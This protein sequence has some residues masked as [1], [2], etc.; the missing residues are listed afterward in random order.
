[1]RK[2]KKV[3]LFIV[4]CICVVNLI[5]WTGCTTAQSQMVRNIFDEMYYAAI[6][7]YIYS[8]SLNSF[9]TKA[10]FSNVSSYQNMQ[11]EAQYTYEN[12]KLIM[13]CNVYKHSYLNKNESI[14]IRANYQKKNIDFVLS[15]DCGIDG[16]NVY[17]GE[18]ILNI[19][20]RYNV[21]NQCL[22]LS[23]WIVSDMLGITCSS[24]VVKEFMK[25]HNI[26]DEDLEYYKNYM[27][28]EK[29][30]PDWIE[31]NKKETKFSEDN[32]GDFT[33]GG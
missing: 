14:V 23:I 30:I 26:S 32:W 19:C 5:I 33:F 13:A 7:D 3:L 22:T 25:E 8:G 9:L 16:T 20:Y 10:N 28:C 2:I 1:M 31:G 29:I 24:E 21:E 11:Y 6:P 17:Y 12:Q 18:N 4:I 27:L 15:I